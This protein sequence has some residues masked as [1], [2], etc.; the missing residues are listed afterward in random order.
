[1][2]IYIINLFFFIIWIIKSKLNYP[3]YLLQHNYKKEKIQ[4]IPLNNP[5]VKTIK[6]FMVDNNLYK[7]GVIVSLSGGVDSMVILAVLLRLQR[8]KYFN[9][10]IVSIN[11]NLRYESKD[12]MKFLSDYLSS[13]IKYNKISNFKIGSIK[14]I[15]RKNNLN[16]KIN[17][18]RSE[19]EEKSKN[20]RF[21]LYKQMIIEDNYNGVMVAHHKDDLIEN[22]FTNIM[23][24]RNILDLT[25]LKKISN[26]K[27]VKIFRPL[28]DHF[29]NEIYQLAHD[30]NIPYF[31]DT[32]P[33]W[34][35]RGKMRNEIFPLLKK[36]FSDS[37]RK[38][39]LEIG[40]MSDTT[41]EY[42]NK[43][44][45][46]IFNSKIEIFSNGLKINISVDY[47]L[48]DKMI[49]QI[50]LSK[51]LHNLG[52][53]MLTKKNM[54]NIFSNN[55]N[56]NPFIKLSKKYSIYYYENNFYLIF[57]KVKVNINTKYTK[58]NIE[59]FLKGNIYVLK[60][61]IKNKK[62]V[63]NIFNKLKLDGKINSNYK[64]INSYIN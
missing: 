40:K 17:V 53:S 49:W 2:I 39:L 31:L 13:Y 3:N 15:Y 4:N 37:Y 8:E 14:D 28:I 29:K 23:Y 55:F 9:I 6:K 48:F 58:I 5:L 41:A 21:D 45:I 24:G 26:K 57:N 42:F 50:S 25:V 38:K 46:N 51:K 56:S 1:M 47:E 30:Y 27:G 33:K 22:I 19:F 63:L 35:K 34:S 36:V 11:Y 7:N 61:D 52:F 43:K 32:T 59:D 62:F 64:L 44:I 54:N 20:I 60:N 12:E 10:G 18:K 16:K